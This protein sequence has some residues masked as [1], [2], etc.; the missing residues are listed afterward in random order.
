VRSELGSAA[1]VLFL[2]PLSQTPIRLANLTTLC[3]A[4]KIY[5]IKDGGQAIPIAPKKSGGLRRII[6]V[7]R[8]NGEL[9]QGISP[10]Q[11]DLT[12]Y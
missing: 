10:R 1:T 2:W 7:R 8:K 12:G 9:A 3:G 6:G 5:Q 4:K 11:L